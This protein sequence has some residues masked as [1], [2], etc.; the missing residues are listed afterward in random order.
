MT[1]QLILSLPG[2]PIVVVSSCRS[3]ISPRLAWVLTVPIGIPVVTLARYFGKQ[4]RHAQ[5]PK[6]LDLC[7]PVPAGT[8]QNYLGGVVFSVLIV[9]I[10]A[11]SLSLSSVIHDD[12]GVHNGG[13]SGGGG[14]AGTTFEGYPPGG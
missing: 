7:P 3:R 9:V 8:L 6:I 13:R 4:R 1:S 2:P 11:S 10:S 12:A 5:A 14:K